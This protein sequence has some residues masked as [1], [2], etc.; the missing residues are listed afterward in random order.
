MTRSESNAQKAV[1]FSAHNRVC[2]LDL[3]QAA[4]DEHEYLIDVLDRILGAATND[5]GHAGEHELRG[6]IN[7]IAEMARFALLDPAPYI[8]CRC[9]APLAANIRP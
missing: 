5:N 1:T 7:Q 6:R 9:Q 8:L 2:P 4:R 3:A